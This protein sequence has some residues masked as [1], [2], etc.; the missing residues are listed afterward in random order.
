LQ[1]I[2]ANVSLPSVRRDLESNY[3]FLDFSFIKNPKYI[4]YYMSWQDNKKESFIRLIGGKANFKR[5]KEFLDNIFKEQDN[6][7]Q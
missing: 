6:E 3:K 7:H 1:V 4:K 5:T 2:E